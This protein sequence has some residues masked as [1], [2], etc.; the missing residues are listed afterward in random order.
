MVWEKKVGR[1]TLYA[2][3]K[4]NA[5]AI[6]YHPLKL[7]YHGLFARFF[8]FPTFANYITHTSGQSHLNWF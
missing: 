7:F 3:E 1:H 2:N 8:Y 6:F 4:L 5:S